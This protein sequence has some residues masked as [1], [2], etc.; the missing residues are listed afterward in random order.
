MD[1]MLEQARIHSSL[2]GVDA[3]ILADDWGSQRALLINPEAWRKLFKPCYRQLIEVIKANG[4]EV[5]FH[6]DGNVLDLY[7][8]WVELGV[9]AINTQISCMG[10]ENVAA[11]MR[12][13]IAAW[14]ELDRQNVLPY[15]KPADVQ[16]LIDAIKHHIATPE[17]GLIGQFEAHM[18]MPIENIRQGLTGWNEKRPG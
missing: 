17:G 10:V 12:G 7:D 9:A 6:S 2:E 13:R 8:D 15:Q 4:K 11:K 16:R 14:G 18:D 1:Y 5:F 3:C